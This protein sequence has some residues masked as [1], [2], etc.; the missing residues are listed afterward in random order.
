ME[1]HER[2]PICPWPIAIVGNINLDI[3]TSLIAASDGV[4]SDGETGIDE[5]YESL[6]GGGAN[7]A[8]AAAQLGGRVCFFG[9]VGDDELGDRLEASLT[10]YG[11]VTHLTRKGTATGRSINLNW[12][13]GS[14]HFISSLPNNRSMTAEDIDVDVMI[15]AG[16]RQLLRADVWFSEAMLA[17]GNYGLL[18]RVR[19]AGIETYL[20]IN[21]DPEWTV[22]G[23]GARVKQRREQLMRILPLVD[24]AHA[25]EREL[26]FFTGCEDVR[27]G[28]RF[29]LEQGCSGVVVHRGAKGA[30]S[31]HASES[32]IEVPAAPVSSIVCSTACGDVFCAAHILLRNLE[33]RERLSASARI[34]ADHLSGK[35][36]LIPRLKDRRFTER[37]SRDVHREI[38]VRS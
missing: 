20:D 16:C 14:R 10:E 24:V 13:N 34:A 19:A 6:G 9:C 8:L 18:R 32:W 5:I 22:P 37:G 4:M 12:N 21:W 26:A 35:R 1:L 23:N 27:D 36:I 25:N 30:A 28:C 33:S 3:K 17:E 2:F 29:L 31:F 11:I 15:E 7:T 38:P